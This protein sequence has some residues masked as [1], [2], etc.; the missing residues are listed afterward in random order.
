MCSSRAAQSAQQDAILFPKQQQN[1]S[2]QKNPK[3]K[4]SLPGRTVVWPLLPRPSYPSS[5]PKMA[6]D[7][8]VASYSLIWLWNQCCLGTVAG[9]GAAVELSKIQTVPRTCAKLPGIK[10]VKVGENSSWLVAEDDLEPQPQPRTLSC[11]SKCCPKHYT[12][13]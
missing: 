11:F 8:C 7:S 10:R 1:S 5:L 13:M 3:P 2:K 9:E 12:R 6:P 4:Q